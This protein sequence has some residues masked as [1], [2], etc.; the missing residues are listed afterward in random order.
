VAGDVINM[1]SGWKGEQM[2]EKR[3]AR[4]GQQVQIEGEWCRVCGW[5]GVRVVGEP[6]RGWHAWEGECEEAGQEQ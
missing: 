2:A 3:Q 5:E 6:G 4:G 1:A